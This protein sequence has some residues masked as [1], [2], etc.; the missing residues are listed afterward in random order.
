MWVKNGVFKKCI[1]FFTV[2]GLCCCTGFFFFPSCGKQGN[3]LA[4][5]RGLLLGGFPCGGAWAQGHAGLLSCSS[6]APR[7]W[8]TSAIIVVHSLGTILLHGTWG[9]PRSGTE[10]MSPALAGGFF[11]SEPPGKP[12]SPPPQIV[13]YGQCQTKSERIWYEMLINGSSDDVIDDDNDITIAGWL[14]RQSEGLIS[15]ECRFDRYIS[16]MVKSLPAIRE[17]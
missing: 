3:P 7:L 5:A 9:H 16:Q 4:A 14:H 1:Y 2:L 17:T 10:L 11:T 6:W 15:E 12:L 13:L 8:S